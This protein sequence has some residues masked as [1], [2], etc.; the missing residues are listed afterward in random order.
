[1][2][3]LEN[4]MCGLYDAYGKDGF[5]PDNGSSDISMENGCKFVAASQLSIFE[6]DYCHHTLGADITVRLE[7]IL[8]KDKARAFALKTQTAYERISASKRCLILNLH[9]S[10]YSI[11]TLIVHLDE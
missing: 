10:D 9:L 3:G 2:R 7:N 4:G 5:L 1:M 6:D 11:D 8:M